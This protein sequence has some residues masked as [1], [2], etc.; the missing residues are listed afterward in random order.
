ML[1][2]TK[3]YG[4]IKRNLSRVLWFAWFQSCDSVVSSTKP[5]TYEV[6]MFG[7]PLKSTIPEWLASQT[8]RSNIVDGLESVQP[9]HEEDEELLVVK[10]ALN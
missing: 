1:G 4:G 6:P 10:T 9:E 5:Q 2:T 3:K 8:M 7:I